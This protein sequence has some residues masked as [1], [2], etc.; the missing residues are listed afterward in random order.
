MDNIA[1]YQNT[2]VLSSS[3]SATRIMCGAML[4]PTFST[5][6]GRIFFDSIQNNVQ[7]A[8]AGGLTFIFIKGAIKI[9]FQH[10]QFHRRRQRKIMDYN[11]ENLIR[12][13]FRSDI[14][15]RNLLNSNEH[16]L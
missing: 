4:L 11:E 9:Y 12:Y 6:F 3:V 10:K 7:R 15:V 16:T 8:I 5:L 2:V 1:Q 13:G 14:R